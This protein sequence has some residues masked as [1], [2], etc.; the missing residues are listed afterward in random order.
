M[1]LIISV[2][3]K[4]ASS[5]IFVNVL[6]PSLARALESFFKAAASRIESRSAIKAAKA[7]KTAE[8]LREASKRL[9]SASARD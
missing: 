8:E 5:P 7:A 4:I 3:A 9:T 2:L 1:T 6:V